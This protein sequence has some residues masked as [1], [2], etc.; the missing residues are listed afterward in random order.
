MIHWRL[1]LWRGHTEYGGT[2]VLLGYPGLAEV[3]G[4]LVFT[5]D[6]GSLIIYSTPKFQNYYASIVVQLWT[7]AWFRYWEEISI[8]GHLTAQ[9]LRC[10]FWLGLNLVEAF[11]FGIRNRNMPT[12]ICILYQQLPC[13]KGFNTVF[14]ALIFAVQ[15]ASCLVAEELFRSAYFIS[16]LMTNKW[17]LKLLLFSH[18][19]WEAF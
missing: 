19:Q 9:G 15:P 1:G 16:D 5:V 14:T 3:K 18:D 12:F 4:V 11:L 17:Y 8:P 7:A 6:T 10:R 13:H 2:S